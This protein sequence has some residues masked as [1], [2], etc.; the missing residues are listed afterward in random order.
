[1]G[2]FYEYLSDSKPKNE[3]LS[4]AKQKFIA[5]NPSKNHPYY[6]AGFV[7][8]GNTNPISEQSYLWYILGGFLGL[9]VIGFLFYRQRFQ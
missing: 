4:L 9:L 3:A 1:M 6:W 8:N 5:K 2:Y 7:L